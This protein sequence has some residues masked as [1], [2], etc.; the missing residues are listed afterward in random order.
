MATDHCPTD[1]LQV[2]KAFRRR[3]EFT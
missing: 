1:S 3:V 2:A